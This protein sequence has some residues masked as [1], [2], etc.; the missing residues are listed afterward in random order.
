MR[1][2]LPIFAIFV[3]VGCDAPNVW[4]ESEIRQIAQEESGDA[5]AYDDTAENL[6]SEVEDMSSR[7]DDL[8]SENLNLEMEINNVQSELDSHKLEANDY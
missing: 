6:R 5:A 3:L 8:E 7:I 4:R 1:T 2:A